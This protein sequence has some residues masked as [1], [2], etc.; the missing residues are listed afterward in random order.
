[1]TA[2]PACLLLTKEKTRQVRGLLV[3]LTNEGELT[4]LA[5]SSTYSFLEL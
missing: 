1:M 2:W 4:E 3:P 5:I